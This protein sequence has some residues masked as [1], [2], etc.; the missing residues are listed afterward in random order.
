MRA[1]EREA[2]LLGVVQ[3]AVRI[4]VDGHFAAAPFSPCFAGVY[5]QPPRNV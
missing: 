5:N 2:A 4:D 1:H 3:A